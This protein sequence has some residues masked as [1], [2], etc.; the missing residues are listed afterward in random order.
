MAKILKSISFI[1]LFLSLSCINASAQNY[2]I[3]RA[4]PL[5]WWV[6]MHNPNLQLMLYGNNLGKLTPKIHYK[7]I[8]IKRVV[9][10]ENDNYLF[11]YLHI[12]HDTQPGTLDIKLVRNGEIKISYPYKLKKRNKGSAKR[13]G[14]NNSDVIYLI[15]PDRF[16]NGNPENDNIKGYA[17]KVNRQ[18]DFGRHGGDIQG[19]I[20]HLDYIR[21]MGFTA[22]WLNPILENAMPHGSYHGYAITDYYHIDPRFGNNKLYKKLSREARERGIKLI[23]DVVTNHAGSNFWMLKDPPSS[24]WFHH[25]DHFIQTNNRHTTIGNPYAAKID[26]KQY[27]HGWF[28][29][30]M[31]DWNQ[32]NPL[33]ADYLIENSIWWIEYTGLRGI[34]VDT[35][36]YNDRDFMKK[37]TGRIMSEYS[38]FNI[39]GEEWASDP[40]V[41]A[42]W[43]R[44]NPRPKNF[45]SYLPS[46]FDFPLQQALSRALTQKPDWSSGFIQIYN[47]LAD[48]YLYPN[49]FNLVIFADNHDMDRFY[50][51]V[52]HNYKLFKMGI[53]FIMT[54]RGIPEFYYGD[55]ILMSNKQS[56]NDGQ[57][58]SDFP[59][60]WASDT[61]NA[62]TG[63]GLSAKQKKVQSFV[64]KLVNW[65]DTHP[66]VQNGKL[67]MYLP[68]NKV[69]VY[70]RYNRRKTV[71]AIFNKANQQ[72]TLNTDR[73]YER[74]GNYTKGTDV[75][76]GKTYSLSRLKVP[77]Q[78]VLVL[79]LK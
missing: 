45:G 53:T 40:A 1:L 41:V 55:E 16:A 6:G 24:D 70:F 44:G 9:R 71:M 39:V 73:F 20:N 7:G 79:V 72:R 56:E 77:E 67:M 68:Q 28:W 27:T 13:E 66:V 26:Q 11:I 21:K 38:N 22:I 25:Q 34:R 60:G 78:S 12:L 58:R 74:I 54:M 2:Q 47:T 61:I 48:D 17:D 33:V 3:K 4:A 37:W 63:Q 43:Q 35:Y 62:F 19:I 52:H 50:R 65:R 8:E 10:V 15:T 49:P 23:M 46:L 18:D 32:S 42:K 59:G 36:S 14:F 30:T 57:I 5:N 76:S 29:K 69:F 64:K 31:P 75:L 51:Q